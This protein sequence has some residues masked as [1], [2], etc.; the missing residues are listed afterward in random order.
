MKYLVI[1][2]LYGLMKGL[3]WLNKKMYETDNVFLEVLLCV[4]VAIY[5]IVSLCILLAEII[6]MFVLMFL[7]GQQVY[8]D[9]ELCDK[10]DKLMYKINNKDFGLDEKTEEV[11]KE[12]EDEE[13]YEETGYLNSEES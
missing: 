10:V 2:T 4:G 1:G 3:Y 12:D 6:V 11:E 13:L 7:L 9:C 5:S 8:F